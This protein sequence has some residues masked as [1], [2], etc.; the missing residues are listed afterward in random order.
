MKKDTRW[1]K[2]K[3]KKKP[4]QQK[5]VTKKKSKLLVAKVAKEF[6]LQKRVRIPYHTDGLSGKEWVDNVVNS[7]HPDRCQDVFGM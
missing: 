3:K 5:D 7:E 2:K 4:S 6:N 1:E